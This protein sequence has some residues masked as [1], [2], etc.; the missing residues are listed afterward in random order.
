MPPEQAGGEVDRVGERSDVFGLGAVL[1]AILTGKP[2]YVG[3]TNQ[4][5]YLQAAQGDRAGA[6]ARLA[7]CG[8]DEELLRLAQDCLALS[9]R[10]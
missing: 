1:C 4:E 5:V 8:A 10:T 2:P 7:A 9:S 6:L 3:A